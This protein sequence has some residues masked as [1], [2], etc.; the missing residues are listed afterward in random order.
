M[1]KFKKSYN[2]A[3]IILQKD[4]ERLEELF[5][6]LSLPAEFTIVTMVSGIQPNHDVIR[7]APRAQDRKIHHPAI[8][9]SVSGG[10]KVE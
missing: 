2:S 4:R 8:L 3:K 9:K 5:R 7:R 6:V 1:K 10:K